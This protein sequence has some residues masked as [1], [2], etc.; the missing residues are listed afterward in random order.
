MLHSVSENTN[1]SEI[2]HSNESWDPEKTRT[3]WIPAYAGMTEIG[4]LRHPA[5]QANNSFNCIS[6]F[7]CS[8]QVYNILQ[9]LI[10]L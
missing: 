1:F 10:D 2:H 8:F 3:Y 6:K 5:T 4:V 9:P 7:T